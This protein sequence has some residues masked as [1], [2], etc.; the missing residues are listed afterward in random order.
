MKLNHIK[1]MITDWAGS[2]VDFGSLAPTIVLVELFAD[3]KIEISVELARKHMG[4]A[5]RDHIEGILQD[6]SVISQWNDVY[7]RNPEEKDLDELYGAMNTKLIEILPNHADII[8]GVIEICEFLRENNIPLGSTTGYVSDMMEVLVPAAAKNGFRPD[9][10]VNPTDV[11]YGRPAPF[12]IFENMKN[13]NVYP[14]WEMVKTGDT[15]ADINE[16]LSANMWVVAFTLSGNENGLT[17]NQF[18]ALTETEKNERREK[19]AKKFKDAGAHF[20]CDGMW[21]LK[22]VLVEIDS[23]IAQN[24]RPNQYTNL[25]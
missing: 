3:K 13:M 11:K 16:G 14:C 9:S 7:N 22:D 6:E 12:M 20:I 10:I 8:P 5:K 25:K 19:A 21:Q 24:I 18:E 2:A 4:V 17:L 23:L 1:G 15:I